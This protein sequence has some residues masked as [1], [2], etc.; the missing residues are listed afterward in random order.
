MKY[1]QTYTSERLLPFIIEFN[2]LSNVRKLPSGEEKSVALLLDFASLV[3]SNFI[4][5]IIILCISKEPKRYLEG[6]AKFNNTL[7]E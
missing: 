6:Y 3:G 2:S 1:C 7:E 5:E 4:F